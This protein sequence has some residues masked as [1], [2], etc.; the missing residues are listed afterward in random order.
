MITLRNLHKYFNKG[1]QNELHVLNDVTLT[2][3]ERGMVAIFGRSGCGKTT[4]L[5]VIGG[6]DGFAA[7]SLSVDGAD[8]QE[9]ADLIRNRSMGYIFQNYNLHKDRTC[10]DNVADALLLCGMKDRE[11]ISSRV[12]AA[13]AAVDMAQFGARTPDTLSG[14]QQ[15]RIA[16]ARAIVK[17]PKI[18]LA[19]E[20]TGN[21]DEANTLMIMNLLKE[22]SRDHL[23]LLVTHEAYL[24]DHFCDTVIELK[25][26]RVESVREN[27]NANGMIAKAK[28]T[29]Y[30]GE[31]S[32]S[33][34]SS[35]E[36]KV[37]YYGE[38]PAEPVSLRIV[39]KDGRVYVQI[40]SPDVRVLDDSSELRLCEGVFDGTPEP[41]EIQHKMDL[42]ALTPFEGKK[43]GSLFRLAPSILS[44][45]RANFQKQKKGKRFLRACLCLFA[46]VT[47]FATAAFGTVFGDMIR[48]R[49]SYSHNT[50]YVYT[51]DGALSDRL[52]SAMA[53]GEH[54]I[55]ALYITPQIPTGDLHAKFITGYFE[56]FSTAFYDESFSSNAVYLPYSLAEN[57]EL[58]AGNRDGSD[59][60]AMLISSAVADELIETSSV[61]YISSY[62]DL[63]GLTAN[64]LSINGVPARIAG[65]I[66]GEERAVYV[67]RF[68]FEQNALSSMTNLSL[69]RDYDLSLE[70]GEIILAI[71]SRAE[72][73]VYPKAGETLK[74]HGKE[75]KV[76][77]VLERPG[78]FTEWLKN[79][80]G[81]QA[82]TAYDYFQE[83]ARKAPLPDIL[84]EE[85]MSPDDYY[86]RIA[87][88]LYAAGQYA[89]ME[90][91]ASYL[92]E[93]ASLKARFGDDPMF[94][95]IYREMG[96]E[97]CK[98]T[99]HPDGSEYYRA[100]KFKEMYGA[101]P[102]RN[103][104]E[105]MQ[106]LSEIK[107]LYEVLDPYYTSYTGH[108]NSTQDFF[109]M[110]TTLLVHPD[111]YAS[112][113]YRYGEST[114][115]LTYASNFHYDYAYEKDFMGNSVI[116]E[117]EMGSDA[118]GTPPAMYTVI[119]SADPDATEAFLL[120]VCAGLTPP[121]ENAPTLLTPS[122]LHD[123]QMDEKGSA[124]FRGL[125]TV[126]VVLALLCVCMYFIMRSALMSR[127][128]EV[129]I[130]RAIGVSR[131][132]LCFRFLVESL[133]LS[134]LTVFIG[135]L[136]SSVIVRMLLSGSSLMSGM[137]F[138][139]L[140]LAAAVLALLYALSL[141]CGTIPILSLMRK[142][143]SAILAKYDI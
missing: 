59:P 15:Q 97:D 65:V 52:T 120:E 128:K 27:E 6:L 26:G 49:E 76:K 17:N 55:D 69:A 119:H 24:V 129:G 78:D 136:G 42:S 95:Y 75:F 83:E 121:Y 45:Y 84:P 46:A 25:D 18:L 3:P 51:P 56:T 132:N 105:D 36:A 32:R 62:K 58:L 93:Y 123:K 66:K 40:T 98:Y 72:D 22:L 142:S 37:E 91:I 103:S 14:G 20:P 90:Q 85:W 107:D 71:K 88:E 131:K 106:K 99:F 39:N 126:G 60:A 33:D 16:I 57:A 96:V 110:A 2:L 64:G 138:Y 68:Y 54:G 130:Y 11:E 101:Y 43:F 5:N 125:V 35:P 4:L 114:D 70:A 92:D 111:D 82:K 53:N 77:S 67:S 34:L 86:L 87:D 143:P 117:M 61:G 115:L 38:P 79:S 102:D 100:V 104:T 47:V 118:E 137:L 116:V 133:V 74:I 81:I 8:I 19:D 134:T 13:L 21:L 135:F 29:I 30:L 73:K 80:Y 140:W 44:G 28:N 50:F 141:V 48:I 127:I 10:F 89:Y 109:S 23:V 63:I 112:L 41:T 139:P 122:D 94:S 113:A 108:E 31:L 124:I 1:R 9:D 7:G 12:H